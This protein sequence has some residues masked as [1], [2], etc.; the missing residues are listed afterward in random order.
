MIV[1]VMVL[2]HVMAPTVLY[3]QDVMFIQRPS[4]HVGSIQLV[5]L[6]SGRSLLPQDEVQA[7]L[8]FKPHR[9]YYRHTQARPVS[10]LF[11]LT[12]LVFKQNQMG[13]LL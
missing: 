6:Q 3:I 12:V 8:V 10:Q 7:G 9:H 13:K 4:S 1:R 11:P 5:A 2:C